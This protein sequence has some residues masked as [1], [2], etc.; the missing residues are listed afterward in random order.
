[1]A[2]FAITKIL[3]SPDESLVP[4]FPDT[5]KKKYGIDKTVPMKE[6]PDGQGIFSY[7]FNL[8]LTS[9]NFTS[10]IMSHP[11]KSKI[12]FL[13]PGVYKPTLDEIKAG[14]LKIIGISDESGN[15]PKIII[16]KNL[17]IAATSLQFKNVEI[18][19]EPGHYRIIKCSDGAIMCCPNDDTTNVATAANQF[20]R[21]CFKKCLF[22]VSLA[23]N[24]ALNVYKVKNVSFKNCQFKFNGRNLME[25]SLAETVNIYSNKFEGKGRIEFHTTNVILRENQ[26]VGEI[27][28]SMY[29]VQLGEIIRNQFKL[30][31]KHLGFGIDQGSD[32]VFDTNHL[33]FVAPAV[34]E[35]VSETTD[36]FY[37][38]RSSKC[39][40]QHSAINLGSS[41]LAMVQWESKLY[42]DSN[43]FADAKV[44]IQM[45]DDI[46]VG[47]GSN[48]YTLE[49]KSMEVEFVP[50][51]DRV[52]KP[53]RRYYAC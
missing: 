20:K 25:V 22:D 11:G 35:A 40:I 5:L 13:P 52:S 7:S 24:K 36:L 1:M 49:D 48:T 41:S 45:Y 19:I 51:D 23:E 2:Y 46:K 28:I 42:V 47:V 18:V 53:T 4:V 33:E 43:R 26:F 30:S 37:L 21:L 14:Y 27:Y 8:G 38:N 17:V 9:D 50:S 39:R 10:A 16:T 6:L 32:I 31:G 15:R 44:P 29:A 3:I 34:S 12:I